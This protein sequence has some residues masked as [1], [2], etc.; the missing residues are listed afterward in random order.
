M[1]FM[2]IVPA[3]TFA[4]NGLTAHQNVMSLFPGTLPGSDSERRA[5]SNILFVED[6]TFVAVRSDTPAAV[7]PPGSRAYI[8][9]G[10]PAAG[11]VVRF[12]LTVNAVRR[13]RAGGVEPVHDLD[14]WVAG[15]LTGAL[16][17]VTVLQHSR[18]TR[19]SGRSPIQVD[20]VDG[21]AV[22]GDVTVL[23]GLLRF[24]VGRAKAYGCGLLTVAS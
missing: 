4:G 15:K 7:T 23:A 6:V 17:N 13:L 9:R 14:D 24:G 11:T 22:V 3:E 19:H 18:E 12:R 21:Q 10:V 16:T 5:G 1:S 20:T 2:T 8:E